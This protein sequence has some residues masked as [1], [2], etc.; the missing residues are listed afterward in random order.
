MPPVDGGLNYDDVHTGSSGDGEFGRQVWDKLE[1]ENAIIDAD[2]HGCIFTPFQGQ[3]NR[4]QRIFVSL[5]RQL[6]GLSAAPASS[7]RERIVNSS[8][9]DSR[10]SSPGGTFGRSDDR[11]EELSALNEADAIIRKG[12]AEQQKANRGSYTE[13]VR[14]RDYQ[15]ASSPLQ[16]VTS[17]DTVGSN[18][19]TD[20]TQGKEVNSNSPRKDEIAAERAIWNQPN[21]MSQEEMATANSLLMSRLQLFMATPSVNVPVS[22]FFYNEEHSRQKTVYTDA[23]GHFALRAALDFVPTHVR[24]L[25][26]EDLSATEE[27]TVIEP[28]GVSVISDI[29]DTIKHS[30][31]SSGA[32]EIFRNAFTRELADLT[33][34]GVKELYNSLISMGVHIHYVSNS[35]WQMFPVLKQFFLL[36]GLPPGS[37][38]LKQ[39]SGMLQGIFE[40][41]AER[42]KGTLDRLASDFPDRKFILVGDSGEADLEVYT[43]FALENPGRI[44]GIFIRDITTSTTKAFFDSAM[45]PF[46]SGASNTLER[47]KGDESAGIVRSSPFGGNDLQRRRIS[48]LTAMSSAKEEEVGVNKAVEASLKDA[49]E[50]EKKNLVTKQEDN[51]VKKPLQS[52]WGGHVDSATDHSIRDTPPTAGERRESTTKLVST[53]SSS[54]PATET[55]ETIGN[56]AKSGRVPRTN[57]QKAPPPPAAK[58]IALRSKAT[59]TGSVMQPPQPRRQSSS[60]SRVAPVTVMSS[61]YQAGESSSHRNNNNKNNNNN[62][63]VQRLHEILNSQ[64]QAQRGRQSTVSDATSQ[65]NARGRPSQAAPEISSHG[66]SSSPSSRPPGS[67]TCDLVDLKDDKG[68]PPALPP[69][70]GFSSYSYA[71]AQSVASKVYGAWMGADTDSTNEGAGSSV[72]GDAGANNGTVTNGQVMGQQQQQQQKQQNKDGT[73]ATPLP[74]PPPPPPRRRPA[75]SSSAGSSRA[76]SS[77]PPPPPPNKKEE[78][79]Q[80]RWARAEEL[81]RGEGV[82]LRSW[83]VGTEVIGEARRLVEKAHRGMKDGN[84]IGMEGRKE[85]NEGRGD[86]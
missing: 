57:S 36:A 79:W 56:E 38:H 28:R 66:S 10:A 8:D 26:G 74:P 19:S 34:D 4:R 55:P 5:A 72:A 50:V 13:R 58:P 53:P 70:R 33:I 12:E 3:M 14:S 83:R 77:S 48:G 31:I 29:D 32:R 49:N 82:M 81:L 68:N 1:D 18:Y 86:E 64:S 75:A 11:A 47:A 80:R 78:M 46:A 43:D 71:A 24:V 44:L 51:V 60:L 67:A 30:A 63:P 20:K 54:K 84:G 25:A 42:K 59:E 39:Y 52:G 85:K 2:V 21:S 62:I 45:A 15:A 22:A 40:P 37:F 41:V 9:S 6:V 7:V 76:E 69:R 65:I 61:N 23:A 27:V 17:A 16:K 73:S 35:P